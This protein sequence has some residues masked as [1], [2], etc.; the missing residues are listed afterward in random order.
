MGLIDSFPE[1]GNIVNIGSAV[2]NAFNKLMDN[3]DIREKFKQTGV[4]TGS[5][6]IYNYRVMFKVEDLKRN[7]IPAEVQTNG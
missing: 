1:I 4:V 6:T 7:T 3:T 2:V 5:V